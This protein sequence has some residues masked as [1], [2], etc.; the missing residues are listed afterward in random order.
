MS[1]PA[2]AAIQAHVGGTQSALAARLGLSHQSWGRYVRGEVSPTSRRL[3]KWADCLELDIVYTADGWAFS[4]RS[5][6]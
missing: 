6:P 1:E 5:T 2:A 4:P 3:A